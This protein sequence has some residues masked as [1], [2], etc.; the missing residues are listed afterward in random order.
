MNHF[1]L[2]LFIMS[3]FYCTSIIN[4]TEIHARVICQQTPEAA[5]LGIYGQLPVNYH[6]GQVNVDIPLFNIT[7]NNFNLP[8][9]LQFNTMG[10][11]PGARPGWVGQNWSLLAG[12]VVTRIVKCIPDENTNLGYLKKYSENAGAN[13]ISNTRIDEFIRLAC[14]RSQGKIVPAD[15]DT[16]PDEF[17][18]SVNGYTGKFCLD[19]DGKFKVLGDPGVKVEYNLSFVSDLSG[20]LTNDCTFWGFKI[21]LVD[22]TI[23]YFGYSQGLI[24]TTTTERANTFPIVK[25]TITSSWQLS[26]I[27]LPKN[28]DKIIF[29]YADKVRDYN[30]FVEI[31]KVSQAWRLTGTTFSLIGNGSNFCSQGNIE[32]SMQTLDHCYLKSIEGNNFKLELFTSKMN[33]FKQINE[34]NP[35][36]QKI[37]SIKLSEKATNRKIKKISFEYQNWNRLFLKSVTE[38]GKPPYEFTY[39][40]TPNIDYS[41]KSLDHWGYYNGFVDNPEMIGYT[42]TNNQ[43]EKKY[44]LLNRET[45]PWAVTLGALKQI[46]YPTGGTTDFEFEANTYSNYAYFSETPAPGIYLKNV[47]KSWSVLKDDLHFQ[48]DQYGYYF[49]ILSPIYLKMWMSLKSNHNDYTFCGIVQPGLHW[50][51]EFIPNGVEDDYLIHDMVYKILE[52]NT[53]AYTGGIRI[54]KITNSYGGSKTIREYKYVKNYDSQPNNK[55][56]SGILGGLPLYSYDVNSTPPSSVLGFLYNYTTSEFYSAA[57][58]SS[59]SYSS[60]TNGSHVGYSEVVE[61]LKDKYDSISG[62]SIYKYSNF[63]TNPDSLPA[64]LVTFVRDDVGARN[65]KAHER[66]K[67]ICESH[68]SKM[69]IKI[70]EKNFVYKNIVRSPIRTIENKNILFGCPTSAIS[71]Q[72]ISGYYLSNDSYLLSSEQETHYSPQGQKLATTEKEYVYNSYN[73]LTERKITDSRNDKSTSK[74]SYSIDMPSQAVSICSQMKDSNILN[75]V[76]KETN[77]LKKENSDLGIVTEAKFYEYIK[78][79]NRFNLKNEY[80]LGINSTIYETELESSDLHPKFRLENT[81]TYDAKGNYCE[82][83]SSAGITTTYLWSYNGQYPVIEIKNATYNQV[84]NIIPGSVNYI[85]SSAYPSEAILSSAVN[86]LKSG[87]PNAQVTSYTYEPLIGILTQTDSR[88]VTTYYEYD[89][90]N[91]LKAIKDNNG[92]LLK[93]FDYN[94]K[95]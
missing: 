76:I 53:N 2:L 89:D 37:D 1:R 7:E 9:S 33:G 31:K 80:A 24:E 34:I 88:G 86:S 56:S 81:F 57:R 48:K 13:W 68:Y 74:Y 69:N 95:H 65:S 64:K 72:V 62:Y 21:T 85:T 26:K 87:L 94:Y 42:F 84:S 17:F 12:G 19:T 39:E 91:R 49:T 25:N 43:D 75:T 10:F 78:D 70:N 59:F 38:E 55:V 90:F 52:D 11:M 44:F 60:L 35:N 58:S 45:D 54:K 67:L 30:T 41:Y 23:C 16:E 83:I 29:N 6:T 66:G 71:G 61:I 14:L 27:I 50:L 73:L 32:N 18:F 47:S 15:N 8:I 77:I 3:L 40:G 20:N 46:K 5:S 82:I 4:A 22:G 92:K 63:D 28:K 36:W 51:R 79:G 93:S